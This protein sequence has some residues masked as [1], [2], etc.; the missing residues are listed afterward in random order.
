MDNIMSDFKE[1]LS[2]DDIESFNL[3]IFLPRTTYTEEDLIIG[4]FYTDMHPCVNLF[5]RILAT[6]PVSVET[7]EHTF[8]T[9]GHLKTWLRATIW[10]ERFTDHALLQINKKIETDVDK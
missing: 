7:V 3:G 4:L 6:P 5:L 8:S 9:H 10:E 1:I 2:P